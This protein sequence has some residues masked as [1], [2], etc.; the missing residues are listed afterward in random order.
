MKLSKIKEKIENLLIIIFGKTI[1][2]V[3]SGYGNDYSVELKGKILHRKLYIFGE[4]IIRS[5]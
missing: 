1:I 4:K 5:K 2:G 3:D